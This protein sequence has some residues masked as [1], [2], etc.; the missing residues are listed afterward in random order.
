[1]DLGGVFIPTWRDLYSFK[2]GVWDLGSGACRFFQHLLF[3]SRQPL[4]QS[5]YSLQHNNH[6]RSFFYCACE[7]AKLSICACVGFRFG[8][9]EGWSLFTAVPI[10]ICQVCCALRFWHFCGYIGFVS[11]PLNIATALFIH[12]PSITFLKTGACP[13]SGS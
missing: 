1:M 8:G 4:Q 9:V 5:L 6:T 7:E 12:T 3:L 13:C 10:I 11:A 2:Q